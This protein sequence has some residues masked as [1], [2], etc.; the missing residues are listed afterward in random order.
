MQMTH[1]WWRLSVVQ[2]THTHT[3]PAQLSGECWGP[4]SVWF[5]LSPASPFPYCHWVE[6]VTSLSIPPS[7]LLTRFSLRLAWRCALLSPGPR[8][9]WS[10][11]DHFGAVWRWSRLTGLRSVTDAQHGE[12][13]STCQRE[14][15]REEGGERQSEGVNERELGDPG[16]GGTLLL[17][18]NW[19]TLLTGVII[20]R[21]A[22]RVGW[23]Y[24]CL[25]VWIYTHIVCVWAPGV[26]FWLPKMISP[27]V[28]C[29][30]FCIYS[31]YVPQHKI[32]WG[33]RCDDLYVPGHYLLQTQSFLDN[34]LS[35]GFVSDLICSAHCRINQ[36]QDDLSV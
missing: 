12:S 24:L 27:L 16:V 31:Q 19:S 35:W 6:R 15:I 5:L 17:R 21:P 29:S 7:I 22:G 20:R 28:K 25:C 8:V 33:T 3:L 32:E 30:H 2:C 9:P 23:L 1:P 10:L 26:C 34:V 36:C 13:C 11:L 14:R 18:A 4:R